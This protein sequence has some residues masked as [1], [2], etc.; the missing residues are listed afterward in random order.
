MNSSFEQKLYILIFI[1]RF[2]T[3]STF[4]SDRSYNRTWSEIEDMLE[5]AITQQQRWINA[6]F[7]AKELGDRQTMRDAARNKKALE[8]VIKTLKWTLGE[9][10]ITNPLS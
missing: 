9:E 3:Q 5:L 6:F 4:A 2:M 10:G 8:G 7:H 1:R